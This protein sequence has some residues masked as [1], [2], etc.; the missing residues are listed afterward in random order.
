MQRILGL[1]PQI[2]NLRA[3]CSVSTDD[4]GEVQTYR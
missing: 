2:V 3:L 1:R 4:A